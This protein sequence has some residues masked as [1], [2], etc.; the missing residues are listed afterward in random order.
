MRS[1]AAIA[2]LAVSASV[3]VAQTTTIPPCVLSCYTSSLSSTTCASTDGQCLCTSTSF[4]QATGNCLLTTCTSTADIQAGVTFGAQT[5]LSYGIT[6]SSTLPASVTSAGAAGS[7]TAAAVVSS[8]VSSAVSAKSSVASAASSVKASAA[9]AVS[10]SKAASASGSAPAASA[11]AKS[12]AGIVKV[13]SGL[14][15]VGAIAALA[16]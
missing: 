7:S 15:A 14:L 2:F 5:C 13:S 6:I 12:G 10:S 4:Q 11:S 3:A 8:A 16:L 1:V 9:S